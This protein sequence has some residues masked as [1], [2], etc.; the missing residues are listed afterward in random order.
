MDLHSVY[1]NGVMLSP[2]V[3][4]ISPEDICKTFAQGVQKLVAV[5][6]ETNIPTACAVPYMINNAF[7]NL[8][9]ISSECDYKVEALAKA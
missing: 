1:D 8:L 2:E 7:K 3:A 4:T 9:A 5:S 6:L